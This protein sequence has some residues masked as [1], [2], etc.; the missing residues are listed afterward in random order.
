MVPSPELCVNRRMNMVKNTTDLTKRD[1]DANQLRKEKKAKKKVG[2]S[3]K[4]ESFSISSVYED[5]KNARAERLREIVERAKAP[6]YTAENVEKMFQPYTDDMAKRFGLDPSE[7]IFKIVAYTND[8]IIDS[9]KAEDALTTIKFFSEN[10]ISQ[11][12]KAEALERG[13]AFQWK[14]YPNGW[15]HGLVITAMRLW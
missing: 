1:A 8:K 7:K 15:D 13:K 9:N 10:W 14:G 5:R 2:S 4:K 11:L 12:N 6:K 3:A